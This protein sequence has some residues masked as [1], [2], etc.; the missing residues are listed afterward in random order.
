MGK[1]LKNACFP[2]GKTMSFYPDHTDNDGQCA[3]V[4]C[5]EVEGRIVGFVVGRKCDEALFL[6][7]ENAFDQCA[8][9]GVDDIHLP[10]LEKEDVADEAAR[11]Q[12][13]IAVFWVHGGAGDTDQ[14]VS[15]PCGELRHAVL[16]AVSVG[17]AD[18]V[19]R[20]QPGHGVERDQRECCG[21]IL[22]GTWTRIRILWI[23]FLPIYDKNELLFVTL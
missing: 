4:G 3:D 7:R 17:D 22:G 20:R 9:G 2:G 13:P 10:P 18:V 8:L 1:N 16:F 6:G 23:H 19:H 14:E 15:T 21:G 11:K 12:V 5:G